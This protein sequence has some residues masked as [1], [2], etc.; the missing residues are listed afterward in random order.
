V[1]LA[2]RT[3]LVAIR[4]SGSYWYTVVFLLSFRL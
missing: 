2:A 4:W 3:H 1:S